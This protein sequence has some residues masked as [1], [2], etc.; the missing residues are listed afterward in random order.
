MEA[1]SGFYGYVDDV[2]D[3]VV[4]GDACGAGIGGYGVA[5]EAAED[6]AEDFALTWHVV[7]HGDADGCADAVW[8]VAVLDEGV[9]GALDAEAVI[10]VV[11]GEC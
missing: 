2:G 8:R 10:G 11:K 3:E 5:D 9:S 7:A 6:G 1:V 4:D